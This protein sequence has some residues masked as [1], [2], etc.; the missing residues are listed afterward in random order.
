[1]SFR[2]L[3]FYRLFGHCQLS[4]DVNICA[5]LLKIQNYHEQNV[6]SERLC[7]FICLCAVFCFDDFKST[8]LTY[9]KNINWK[10]ES[11]IQNSRRNF[12][13]VYFGQFLFLMMNHRAFAK[14]KKKKM[15][16]FSEPR[17]LQLKKNGFISRRWGS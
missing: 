5:F 15:P 3:Q 14:K 2:R 9:R 13:T 1:M 11:T 4:I 7:L 17:W 10:I 6:L 12:C 8:Q 16:R